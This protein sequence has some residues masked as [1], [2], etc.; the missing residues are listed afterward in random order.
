MLLDDIASYI[1]ANTTG[2]TLGTNLFKSRTP[3]TAADTS[4]TLFEAPGLAPEWSFGSTTPTRER[5]RL[6]VLSRSTSYQTARNNAETIHKALDRQ[7]VNSTSVSSTG[8]RYILVR[9]VQ[10][11][12]PIDFDSNVRHTI[13]CNYDIEKERS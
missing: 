1:L 3:E 6:Q 11:P 10:Q 9:A 7:I 8:P 12:F 4:V 13:S 5:P 2:F